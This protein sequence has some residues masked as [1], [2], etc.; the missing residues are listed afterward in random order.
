MENNSSHCCE[1][2]CI[3]GGIWMRKSSTP[4]ADRGKVC[5]CETS[6][7]SVVESKDNPSPYWFCGFGHAELVQKLFRVCVGEGVLSGIHK[8]TWKARLNDEPILGEEMNSKEQAI[9]DTD[10]FA[11]YLLQTGNHL[12]LLRHSVSDNPNKHKTAMLSFLVFVYNSIEESKSNGA[13]IHQ[14][15]FL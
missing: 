10:I 4:F 14:P 12:I 15:H 1:F 9:D 13:M 11:I 7:D 2:C 6:S 8:V 3:N 5:D